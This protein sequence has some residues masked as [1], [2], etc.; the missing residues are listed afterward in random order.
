[1]NCYVCTQNDSVTSNIPSFDSAHYHNITGEKCNMT[2]AAL[3]FYMLQNTYKDT[4][5]FRND[6]AV[7]GYWTM[8]CVI[9]Y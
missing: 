4:V 1:V 9:D 7:F 8:S 2:V 6:T 5:Y 3:N